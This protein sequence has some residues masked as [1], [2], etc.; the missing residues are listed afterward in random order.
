MRTSLFPWAAFTLSGAVVA[1]AVGCGEDETTPDPTGAGAATTTTTSAGAGGAGGTGGDGGAAQGGGGAGGGTTTNAD[2]SP[3]SGDPGTLTLTPVASGI[4]APVLV[5]FAPGDDDRVYIVS[6]AGQIHLLKD[7]A[8]SLFLDVDLDDK[9][10]SG[11]ERGLL[12]LAFH[13]DYGSNGRFFVHYSSGPGGPGDA[14]GDT[15]IQEFQRDPSDPDL[16]TSTPV[17]TVL[18]VSQPPQYANHNGGSIEFNPFDGYLYIG[19]GDG[20]GGGDPL[21]HGQNKDTLLGA[22]LRIDVDGAAPYAIPAG[23]ITDGEPEIYDWGLRNPYRFSFDLCTGDRYIGDVGQNAWEE[24][25]VAA[26]GDGNKNWGWNT[27]EGTHCYS[28]MNGCDDT[29][30]TPPVAEHAHPTA[31]SITGGVVYRGSA[32]PWL[33][34]AYVYGDYVHGK[35]WMLRW[36]NGT[37]AS[38]PT[39]IT[40]QIGTS[41][42]SSFGYDNRGE[43]YIVSFGG[44]VYRVDS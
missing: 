28:P 9:V 19:L 35:V 14:V 18:T 29:G 37:L 27:L 16:A 39:E 10:Q 13:P 41:N 33:R 36:D 20:G 24:I 7:G 30:T 23:N 17:A 25:D 34:G 3:P 6:Q 4:T 43:I 38:G 12:G 44:T 21:G 2:C 5:T 11:G 1:L 15:V 22:L 32:I 40:G 26:H 42:I 8:T 31:Q